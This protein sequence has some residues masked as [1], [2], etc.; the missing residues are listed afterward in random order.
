MIVSNDLLRHGISVPGSEE[1]CE[2]FYLSS[3]KKKCFLGGNC[4]R[5]QSLFPRLEFCPGNAW[6]VLLLVVQV[7]ESTVIDDLIPTRQ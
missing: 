6:A 7:V 4:E 3:H 2:L 5:I 1:D